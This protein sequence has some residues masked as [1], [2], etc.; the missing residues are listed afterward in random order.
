[1]AVEVEATLQ[2]VRCGARR[3]VREMRLRISRNTPAGGI[4]NVH[5]ALP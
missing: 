2:P 3:R 1:M 5:V 4:Q